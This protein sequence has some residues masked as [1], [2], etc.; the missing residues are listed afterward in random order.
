[1]QKAKTMVLAVT[2]LL[3]RVAEMRIFNTLHTFELYLSR[4]RWLLA[5]RILLKTLSLLLPCCWC[6]G[7]ILRCVCLLV[8]LVLLEALR[9]AAERQLC[10][11]CIVSPATR[12]MLWIIELFFWLPLHLLA[13]SYSSYMLDMVAS[14]PLLSSRLLRVLVYSHYFSH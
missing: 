3:A 4:L 1:V 14:M 7:H 12:Q 10:S 13:T 2:L 6:D 11:F 5:N 8:L 9:N